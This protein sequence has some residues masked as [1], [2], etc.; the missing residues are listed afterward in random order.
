MSCIM[1]SFVTYMVTQVLY[2]SDGVLLDGV[3]G[4]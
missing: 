4:Q 2:I 1:S 3:V